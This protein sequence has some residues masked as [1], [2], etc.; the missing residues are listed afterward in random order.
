MAAEQENGSNQTDQTSFSTSSQKPT[1]TY[2]NKSHSKTISFE[3]HSNQTAHSGFLPLFR[4]HLALRAAEERAFCY[5][6][7]QGLHSKQTCFFLAAEG[8]R[9][10]TAHCTDSRVQVSGRAVTGLSHSSCYTDECWVALMIRTHL[11]HSWLYLLRKTGPFRIQ[12]PPSLR[13][14]CDPCQRS[15][16]FC[17]DNLWAGGVHEETLWP[18]FR[19]SIILYLFIHIYYIFYKNTN[20]L[21]KGEALQQNSG[22]S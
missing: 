8:G 7:F 5:Q 21:N 19:Y 18:A 16:L 1:V 11:V 12:R 20:H 3:R 6:H 22:W 17:S 15:S 13:S 2:T 10:R 4:H 9:H 14:H